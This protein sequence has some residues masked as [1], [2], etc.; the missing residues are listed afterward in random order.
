MKKE[1]IRRL[2]NLGIAVDQLVH[3]IVTLGHASPDETISA[4]A[5]R[6]EQKGALAGRVLRPIIDT[7]FR[8]FEHD[9]CRLAYEAEL[10]R[11]HMH[12]A[13]RPKE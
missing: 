1:L 12:V 11:A 13:Y 4:A 8:V 3:V 5:W 9:H 10:A 6:L 7:L 2:L